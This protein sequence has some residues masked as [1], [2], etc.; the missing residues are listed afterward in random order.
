VEVFMLPSIVALA[1][2]AI[3][4]R[5]QSRHLEAVKAPPVA[6]RYDRNWVLPVLMLLFAGSGVSA[7]IYEIVW[8]QLLQLAIGS[9][10]VS[11]GIL[12]ATFMGGLGLG[13]WLRIS[14][15]QPVPRRSR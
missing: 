12:L 13:S 4:P 15:A 2:L 3:R 11:L 7:L 5:V 8:Y 1:A 10:A 14:R 9:T 6:P